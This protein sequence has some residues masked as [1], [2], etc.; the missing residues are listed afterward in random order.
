MAP[1]PTAE[2]TRFTLPARVSPT[3]KIPGMLVSSKSGGRSSG[4][5]HSSEPINSWPVMMNPSLSRTNES[6]SHSVRGTAPA[7]T[8]T[9]RTPSSWHEAGEG[10]GGGTRL[11]PRSR[12]VKS[13]Q[14]V[15]KCSSSESASVSAGPS[16]QVRRFADLQ[17]RFHLS[18]LAPN[19]HQSSA[20]IE[21]DNAR[22]SMRRINLFCQ[23][24]STME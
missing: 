20:M 9:W 8:K 3:A 7:M 10:A 24:S 11:L 18:L 5:S 17:G 6:C 16:P 14:S 12:R 22:Q 2:A 19:R 15:R 21:F 4:H 13:V 1:S 23:F